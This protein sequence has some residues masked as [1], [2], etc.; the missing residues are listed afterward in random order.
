MDGVDET[1]LREHEPMELSDGI[2]GGDSQTE[3][4]DFEDEDDPESE[5]EY[6]GVISDHADFD[7]SES[8][9]WSA[10]NMGHVP[11]R[12]SCWPHFV[13]KDLDKYRQEHAVPLID[14][15][16][17]RQDLKALHL[18]P[19][20]SHYVR[21]WVIIKAYWIRKGY[22]ALMQALHKVFAN[23]KGERGSFMVGHFGRV[24]TETWTK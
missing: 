13:V 19:I 3:D 14:W 17:I 22:R 6:S 10:M 11:G 5:G 24:G 7:A 23:P 16:K 12:I 9:A 21:S 15:N 1:Y 4:S 8:G 18:I 2:S 20:E